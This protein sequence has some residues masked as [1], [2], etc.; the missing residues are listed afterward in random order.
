MIDDPVLFNDWHPVAAVDQLAQQGVLSTR[1]LG[2]ELVIWQSETG[3]HAWQDLCIHRGAR[4]TGGKLIDGCLACPYHGWRYDARGRC[5]HIPAHPEQSPPAKAQVR[6]FRATTRYGLV[7]V[8]LGEPAQTPPPFPEWDAGGYAVAV[9]GPYSH[10]RAHGPRLIENFLDAAHFPFVHEGVLGD[11]DQP[12]MGDYEARITPHGVESDPIAVYQPN[13]YGDK[14]GQVYY[15]YHA[16]RPLTAHFTK[17]SAG[18]TNG[19]LL[20][21]TPHDALD[22]TAWFVVATDTMDDNAELKRVYAPRIATIFEEDRA[23]VEGQRPE[24]LPLDLQAELHLRSDRVAIAYRTWL[25]QLGLT[26]GTR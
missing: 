9:C 12:A 5:V 7:W 22:S 18:A 16:F 14:A 8:C 19:L 17:Q 21:I 1:L 11:P 24:L 6:T 23:V 4:L 2:E 20:T 10:I 15:I 3:I 25:R 26:F 13:P